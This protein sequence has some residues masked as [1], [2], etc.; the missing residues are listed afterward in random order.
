[1]MWFE[2]GAAPVKY[3]NCQIDVSAQNAGETT[4][5]TSWADFVNWYVV[6]DRCGSSFF[7]CNNNEEIYSFHTSGAFFGFGDGS[8]HYLSTDLNPD[9]FVSLFTRE[10]N[11][12]V[13]ENPF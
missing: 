5:G 3:R 2:T 9:V 10:S 12:I 8:V 4:G 6:H 13:N 1:M 11:D 7:N